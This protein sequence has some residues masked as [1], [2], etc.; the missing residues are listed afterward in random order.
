M[1]VICAN[2][3][4]IREQIAESARGCGRNPDE[5][6][7]LAVS[8][9][10]GTEKIAAAVQCGQQLFGENFVQEAKDKIERL[11]HRITWHFIGHLQTNKARLAVRLF[12]MIETV[13]RLKLALALNRHAKELGRTVDILVQVN[14]GLEQQKSGVTPENAEHFL[15]ELGTLHNLRV[16][17]LMTMPPYSEDPERSRPYFKELKILADRYADK[18]LFADNSSVILSMGMSNDFPVAIEEGTTLIRIG[19]AIFGERT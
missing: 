5:I 18:K 1:T 13:D 9:R 10:M 2:I 11:E 8:K 6:K 12:A 7:L 3:N 14:I 17:G 4:R 19:T 16:R 15:K